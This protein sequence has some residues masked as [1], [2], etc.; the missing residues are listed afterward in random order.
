MF[1]TRK[2]TDTKTF[3]AQPEPEPI[4]WVPPTP[5]E[6][7]AWLKQCLERQDSEN[8]RVTVQRDLLAFSCFFLIIALLAVALLEYA[9]GE[10]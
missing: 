6:R 1:D 10:G 4:P 5:E 3:I 2:L 9:S 7:I 8:I